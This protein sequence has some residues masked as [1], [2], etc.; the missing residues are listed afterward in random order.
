MGRTSSSQIAGRLLLTC[1]RCNAASTRPLPM[2]QKIIARKWTSRRHRRRLQRVLQNERAFTYTTDAG[3]R[4]FREQSIYRTF[5]SPWFGCRC[6]PGALSA[7]RVRE[8]ASIQFLLAVCVRVLLYA[9]RRLLFLDNRATRDGCRLVGGCAASI[10]KHRCVVSGAGS[11]FYSN[12]AAAP[13]SLRMDGHSAWACAESGFQARVSQ[14]PLVLHSRDHLLWFLDRCV[15]VAAAF[16]SAPGQGRKSAV[17]DLDAPRVVHQPAT[18]CALS[19][20]WRGRL[21]DE[22][23]LPLVFNHVWGVHLC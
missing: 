4:I 16:F 8:S 11:P 21:D 9:L 2:F 10:G 20:V 19:H 22:P 7:R 3:R 17:H 18:V 5:N 14:F 6:E 13:S 1:A 12:P 15:S 23:Q